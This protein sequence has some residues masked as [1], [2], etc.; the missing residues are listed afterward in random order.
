[1]KTNILAPFVKTEDSVKFYVNGR[2]FEMKNNELNETET[3]DSTLKSAIAAFESFDFSND[4]IKWFHGPYKF[5]YVMN[6]STFMSNTS[7]IE[8]NTFSKHVL[9]AGMVRYE[10]KHKAELFESLPTLLEN[11]IILDFAAT[12][13]G[14]NNIVNVFKLNEEVYV[15]RFN[16][17]NRISKFFKG[18]NANAAAEFVTEQTGESAVTFL[19]DLVDGE[20][21]QLAEQEATIASYNDM[22]AF[23]KD[24]RGLLAEADKS[25]EEIKA[26]DTLISEEIKVWEQKIATILA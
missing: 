26:A 23:L 10:H 11:F 6:E 14:N 1:M 18:S 21:A 3:I 13:E 17:Q 20:A 25:I 12:F 7:L 8:G 19:R 4:S 2:V 24:Q 22:I 15:A 9:S 16:T 5:S